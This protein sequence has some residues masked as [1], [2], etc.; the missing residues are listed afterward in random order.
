MGWKPQQHCFFLEIMAQ[1]LSACWK[2]KCVY[3]RAVLVLEPGW[4]DIINV[5]GDLT[6]EMII[7]DLDLWS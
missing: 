4:Y 3:L 6:L 7:A 5:E 2:D 1:N